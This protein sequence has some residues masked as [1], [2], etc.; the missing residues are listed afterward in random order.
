M[1][2]QEAV[3]VPGH[4]NHID[5]C[6]EDQLQAQI[7]KG[8]PEQ[9]EETYSVQGECFDDNNSTEEVV[10][11][12]IQVKIIVLSAFAAETIHGPQ[13]STLRVIRMVTGCLEMDTVIQCGAET[14]IVTIYV[15]EGDLETIS[16][17]K[18]TIIRM[19]LKQTIIILERTQGVVEY[20]QNSVM[21]ALRTKAIE[22]DRA[23]EIFSYQSAEEMMN[24]TLV[25]IGT[26]DR[27]QGARNSRQRYKC[28][29]ER[30]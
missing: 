4:N 22:G 25:K 13:G 7:W 5:A 8:D 27:D 6:I 20:A 19:I 29:S 15:G 14:Q 12:G 28:L 2:V 24:V 21:Q 23:E 1:I 26:V 3:Q 17:T 9:C 30:R 18:K 16:W 11:G 10:S